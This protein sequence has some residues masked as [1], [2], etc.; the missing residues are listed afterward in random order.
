M[1][2]KSLRVYQLSKEL[3]L[4]VDELVKKLPKSER[5]GMGNQIYRSSRSV[6]ANIAEGYGRRYYPSDYVR[7][8]H[9]SPGSSDETQSHLELAF[10][11][12]LIS[13]SD[14]PDLLKNYKNLSV[15][16]RNLIKA[17]QNS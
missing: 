12:G 7:F 4:S 15:R 6:V 1:S 10:D 14:Y 17:V 11:T 8:L 9:Y 13:S 16:L 2:F 5:F 3:A